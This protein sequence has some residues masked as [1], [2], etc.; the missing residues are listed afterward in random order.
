M[1]KAARLP[2]LSGL[3]LAD[4]ETNDYYGEAHKSDAEFS[5]KATLSWEADLWGSLRWAKRKGAAEYLASVEA[6]RAVQ[7]TLVAE[8]ATAYF[9]LVAL[10]HELG[11]VRRTVE[12]CARQNCVSKAV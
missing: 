6:A 4:N 11:V 9:E 8:V 3:V 7:M 5:V 2:T 1:S 10:D 12:T